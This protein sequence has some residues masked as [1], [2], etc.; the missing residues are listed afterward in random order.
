[1]R[2][3]IGA[4][5]SPDGGPVEMRDLEAFAACARLPW[6]G[7]PRFSLCPGAGLVWI[8]A[9]PAAVPA[10]NIAVFDRCLVVADGTLDNRGELARELGLSPEVTG[11]ADLSLLIATAYER[12]GTGCALRLIGELAFLL[13][14]RLERRLLAVRDACGLR[15]LFTG[16]DGRRL[17]VAS[18]LQMILER[19]TPADVDQDFVADF[20]A[21]QAY[22]GPG[23]PF[24]SVRRIQ[25]GHWLSLSAGSTETRQ[26][27]APGTLELPEYRNDGELAEH[28]LSVLR[29]AVGRCLATGGRVWSELSG[30]LDS[31]SITVLAHE[32]LRSD[33]ERARDFATVT[34]VWDQTPQSDERAWSGTV[35]EQYGLTHHQIVCD[36]LFLDGADEESRYRNEPH[37][38]ILCHPMIRAES[39]HLRDCGVEVLLS[40]AR[41]EAVVLGDWASPL[42]LADLLR[43]RRL[44]AFVD[45]L[46]CWQRSTHRPLANLLWTFALRPLLGRRRYLRSQTDTGSLAPWIDQRFARRMNLRG[47]SHKALAS[48]RFQSI[49]QQSQYEQ[50]VRSEQ[51]IARGFIE[52]SCEIRHPFL[53]RPL[54]ELALAIPW[55]KKA[56][57]WEAKPLLRRALA[58]RLPETVRARRGGAGPGPA[59]YK[60]FA[61]RWAA[62]EPMVRSP[63]LVEMG[64]LDREQFFRAA[65]LVRFGAAQKFV[66]FL[67]CLAFEHWLRTVTGFEEGR[68]R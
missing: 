24:K 31:S 12:W 14:D 38:G 58:G 10:G 48:Q 8:P 26:F 43:S 66:S 6:G 9:H 25:A 50:L 34:A 63:L 5:V 36:D 4:V 22:C 64:F 17:F 56:S 16:N 28:F 32:I 55:E 20:L 54:V 67:S 2:A 18:Q 42:H 65:E 39:E 60:A 21:C 44:G 53:Y 68:F 52:W 45:E 40:G 3:V 30:G 19:P 29:E 7:S 35:V 62:I 61:K 33:P 15:E 1:V 11:A 27:W 13:W 37:F 51:M 57:P 49:A 47:R 46:L 59:I 23:T 41:A